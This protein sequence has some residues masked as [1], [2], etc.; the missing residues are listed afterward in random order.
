MKFTTL[1]E[2]RRL[3]GLSYLG[4]TTKSFKHRKAGSYNELTYAL[5]LAP[6]NT[7]GYGFAPAEQRSVQSSV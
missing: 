4:G 7:S 6:A 3:T 5:Y 2:A 1:T